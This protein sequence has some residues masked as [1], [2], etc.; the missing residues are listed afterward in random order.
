LINGC[1]V[2]IGTGWSCSVPCYN[3]IDLIASVKSWL[4]SDGNVLLEEEGTTV[5][6][7]PAI[8]PWYR[9]YT[10]KIESCGDSKYTSWGNIIE[11][12]KTKVVNELPIGMWTDNFKEYL[13][14]LLEEKVIQKVKNYSTPKHIRF[15]ITESADGLLCDLKNLKLYKYIYTSNMVLFDSNGK[16]TK[17]NN[18]DEI[19]NEF[20]KVRL[21]YYSKRKNYMIQ[22]LEHDIKF[23]G[24]KKRFLEEIMKGDIKLFDDAGKTRKS[25]K[26]LDIFKDLEKRGYDK[27]VKVDKDVK[28]DEDEIDEKSN[29]YD[30]LL[31]LQ[32]RS[33]TEEKI[34]KLK[35][36]IDSKIKIR[37]SL[38]NTT[39]KQMWIQDLD[40]FEK[41]YVKWLKDVEK[42]IVKTNKK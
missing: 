20:C 12:K 37:D 6:L 11:E 22:N 28:E 36:D 16:I 40:E 29:G 19:I 3:P 8:D 10:G 14:D 4:N 2:G 32:F 23:L 30:Y 27:E 7:L 25:R 21:V 41:A 31:R 15:V 9:G 33:I 35:N 42:E 5:S 18:V 34:N 39:E 13:D 17:Y 38:S 24:N 26:T 1:I